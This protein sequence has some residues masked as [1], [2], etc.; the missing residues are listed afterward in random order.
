MCC[1]HALGTNGPIVFR[2]VYIVICTSKRKSITAY[3]SHCHG[4][5]H[6]NSAPKFNRPQ[7]EFST[8]SKIYW[9]TYRNCLRVHLNPI[10]AFVYSL[11]VNEFAQVWN[12]NMALLPHRVWHS[13]LAN[14]HP[15]AKKALVL[16][17]EQ[18]LWLLC[19]AQPVRSTC[20]CAAN[21]VL[22][23]ST[24]VVNWRWAVSDP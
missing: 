15:M 17:G 11:H 13:Y 12:F 5:K 1:K 21:A 2:Y 24:K 6:V 23:W 10:D 20:S 14:C 8:D 7:T 22:Q 16:V 9:Y 3:R 4:N 18:A 19:G